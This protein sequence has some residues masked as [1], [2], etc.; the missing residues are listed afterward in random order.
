MLT[1]QQILSLLSLAADR[2]NPMV[3]R[4]LHREALEQELFRQLAENGYSSLEDF[5]ARFPIPGLPLNL[6]RSQPLA[7]YLDAYPEG[8]EK[9]IIEIEQSLYLLRN[10]VIWDEDAPAPAIPRGGN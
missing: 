4:L 2:V 6:K 5:E 7:W 8:G 10:R 3:E 1:S 9:Y